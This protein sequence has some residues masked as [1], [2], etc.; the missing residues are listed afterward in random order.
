L[1]SEFKNILVQNHYKPND[2]DKLINLI[3]VDSK[4]KD[5]K[6]LKISLTKLK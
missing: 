1:A 6:K 4:D 3:V 5:R 2:L